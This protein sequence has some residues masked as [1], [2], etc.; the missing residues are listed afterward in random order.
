MIANRAPPVPFDNP[1][2]CTGLGFFNPE[3]HFIFFFSHRREFRRTFLCNFVLSSQL[4]SLEMDIEG[5]KVVIYVTMQRRKESRSE[6]A[7]H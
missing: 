3:K 2:F 6:R 4:S 7:F 1:L 5:I